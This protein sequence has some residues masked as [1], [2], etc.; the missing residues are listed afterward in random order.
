[1]PL[2]VA[3]LGRLVCPDLDC[4]LRM[5]HALNNE[6]LKKQQKM[7][8]DVVADKPSLDTIGDKVVIF[9]LEREKYLLRGFI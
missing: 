3:Q 5:R 7:T 1:M 6:T 2:C 9:P 4:A 8:Q